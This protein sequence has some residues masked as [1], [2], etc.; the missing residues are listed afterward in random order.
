MPPTVGFSVENEAP[1]TGVSEL[2]HHSSGMNR[3]V[4]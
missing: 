1:T 4:T 2:W 3:P